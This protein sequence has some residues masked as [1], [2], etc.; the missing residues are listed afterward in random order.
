MYCAK[1]APTFFDALFRALNAR[2]TKRLESNALRIPDCDS[3]TCRVAH[4]SDIA[5][6]I[7]LRTCP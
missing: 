2:L 7:R 1:R 6:A 5:T 4:V 3:G